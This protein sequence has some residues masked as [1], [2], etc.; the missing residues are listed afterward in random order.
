M[1]SSTS[2]RGFAHLAVV[3]LA[4]LVIG[5]VGFAGWKVYDAN[6]AAKPVNNE[7]SSAKT[8]PTQTSQAAVQSVEKELDTVAVDKD[9]DSSALDTDLSD[10]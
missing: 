5:V 8:T 4:V 10:L 6:N 2:Q 7:T 1:K 9:L 3:F